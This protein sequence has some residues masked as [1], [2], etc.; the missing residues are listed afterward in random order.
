M[1]CRVLVTARSE[2]RQGPRLLPR[3]HGVCVPAHGVRLLRLLT[4]PPLL[5]LPWLP[6]LVQLPWLPLLVQLS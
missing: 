4:L 3:V 2:A 5:E 6:L 1:I